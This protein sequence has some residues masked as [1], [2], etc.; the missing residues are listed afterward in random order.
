KR[1]PSC[2]QEG[3][4]FLSL[5]V[6]RYHLT[7]Y[8]CTVSRILAIDYGT[9]KTGIAVTDPLQIVVGGLDTLPTS[10]L[11]DFL[12]D[13][14]GREDVSKIVIGYPLHPDG[15]PAQLVPTIERLAKQ[16][17]KKFSLIEIVF[18]DESFTSKQAK[19]IILQ[20]GHKKKK[21][22]DKTLVDKVSAILILQDYLKH[23]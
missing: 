1:I 3:I 12:V 9:K 2:T 17:G 20:S 10:E 7:F 11:M 14:V 18:H 23:Y 8:L 13:Y 21:R 5:P 16:I 22:R 15:N 19:E 4:P 6:S